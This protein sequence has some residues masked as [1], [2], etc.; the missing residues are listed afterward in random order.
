MFLWRLAH[1]SLPTEDVRK[2]RNMAAEDKCSICGMPDSWRHS[3][4]ECTMARC[5]WALVDPLLMEHLMATTEP[6]AKNWL[7]SMM[8]V[9]LHEHLTRMTVTPWAIWTARRKLIHEGIHQSPLST[10]LFITRYISELEEVKSQPAPQAGA[11]AT[12]RKH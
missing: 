11:A 2:N 9:L 3:L 4:I 8:E 5:V 6:I 12:M 10:H 1:C 7:F